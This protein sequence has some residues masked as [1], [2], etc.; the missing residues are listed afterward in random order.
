M[1]LALTVLAKIRILGDNDI[2]IR[3]G[4]RN[5]IN[6]EQFLWTPQIPLELIVLAPRFGGKLK[7]YAAADFAR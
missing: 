7:Q 1:V 6:E 2:I 5:Q 3:V 4:R